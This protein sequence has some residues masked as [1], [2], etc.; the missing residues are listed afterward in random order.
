ME[1]SLFA[2]CTT[3][4]E[5]IKTKIMWCI[6]EAKVS[7]TFVC[8][9]NNVHFTRVTWRPFIKPRTNISWLF[10]LVKKTIT[11]IGFL[12]FFLYFSRFSFVFK[13]LNF[14]WKYTFG[15][16]LHYYKKYNQIS[17]CFSDDKLMV[18]NLKKIN[19]SWL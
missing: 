2:L 10:L 12:L 18:K 9:Y 11:Y 14:L 6:K 7:H 3:E 16:C 4:R 5:V 17:I 8:H 15:Y 13:K 1:G 19:F